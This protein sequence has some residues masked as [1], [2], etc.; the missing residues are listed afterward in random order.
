MGV[1]QE[2][3]TWSFRVCFSFQDHR[4]YPR[5]SRS[6]SRR[7]TSLRYEQMQLWWSAWNW[8]EGDSR[9]QE[10]YSIAGLQRGRYVILEGE[11]GFGRGEA[12]EGWSDR[13]EGESSWVSMFLI[14]GMNLNESSRV[15]RRW[16]D[17]R[18]EKGLAEEGKTVR[19]LETCFTPFKHS[20][21]TDYLSICYRSWLLLLFE[22]APQGERSTSSSLDSQLLVLQQTSKAFCPLW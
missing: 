15:M 5:I 2:M 8:E 7:L 3:I 13:R 18:R 4:S 12:G 9:S 17:R 22:E 21:D 16:I 11:G 14:K 20:V 1:S 19:D 6:G 10:E